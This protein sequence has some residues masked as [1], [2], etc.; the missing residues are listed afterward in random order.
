MN[1]IDNTDKDFI[2]S[3]AKGL[4]VLRVFSRENPALTLSEVARETQLTRAGAR[5]VLRTLEALGYLACDGR[6]FSLTPRILELGYSYVSSRHWLGVAKPY[7][8]ALRDQIGEHVSVAV[9][10]GTDV[11]YVAQCPIDRVVSVRLEIGMRRPAYCTAMGRVLL[12]QLSPDMARLR[13]EQSDLRKLNS[14]TETDIDLL[15][16]EIAKAGTA[17][18]AVIDQEIED[19]LIAVAVPLADRDGAILA[20]INVC[21]HASQVSLQHLQQVCLP[22]MRVAAARIA[23]ALP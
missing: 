14:R 19:G 20:A 23:Q 11:V 7:L 22:T 5:R 12:A 16:A 21:G 9:L 10:D 17:G 1:A 15:L 8:Q 4:A 13:L 3:L 18:H 6:R 2:H